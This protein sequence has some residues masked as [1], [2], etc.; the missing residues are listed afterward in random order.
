[1]PPKLSVSALPRLL[2]VAK[3]QPKRAV[4]NCN[5]QCEKVQKTM[6]PSPIYLVILSEHFERVSGMRVKFDTVNHW[7]HSF[8]MKTDGDIHQVYKSASG[9]KYATVLLYNMRY[10]TEE[11]DLA[12]T[13]SMALLDESH[14]FH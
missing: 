7:V 14:H 1:M 10:S 12:I 11:A 3:I 5:F 4:T 2:Y 13:Q 6:F 9:L 8:H